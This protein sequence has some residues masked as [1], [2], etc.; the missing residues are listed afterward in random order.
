[1]EKE[2][3]LGN[4]EAERDWGFAGDYVQ[5]MHAC[6]N[7]LDTPEDFV[8]A[9]GQT[10]TVRELVALAFGELDLNYESH[11]VIDQK[12]FR[13]KETIPLVGDASKARLQLGWQPRKSFETMIAEMVRSDLDYFSKL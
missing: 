2:L 6:L 8:I 11:L 4:I 1:M 5:A 10:R 3:R 9:T 13:P 12:F 7:Q